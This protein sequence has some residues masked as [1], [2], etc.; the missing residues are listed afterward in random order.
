MV[1]DARE[2]LRRQSLACV[3]DGNLHILVCRGREDVHGAA[4]RS[5][6]PRI[7]SKGVQHEERKHAV[8]LNGEFCR[9]YFEVYALQLERHSALLH[10]IKSLLKR[11]T[12][13]MHAEVALSQL[14]PLRENVVIVV[15]LVGQFCHIIIS[16]CPHVGWLV[17]ILKPVHL[18]N[19]AVD[20][21]H[22]AV[23]KEYLC[24][25][26]KV[27]LLVVC[28]VDNVKSISLVYLFVFLV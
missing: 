1:E 17:G 22:D 13:N 8:G 24:A 9:L 25:V 4:F 5:E 11:E 10:H 23:H 27:L 2:F 19:H 20:E 26:F 14:N 15:Y 12:L 21:R 6:F 16:L 28:Y 7:V 3:L 18:M